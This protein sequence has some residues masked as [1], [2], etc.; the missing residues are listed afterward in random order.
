[1]TETETF[2]AS[3][4]AVAETAPLHDNSVSNANRDTPA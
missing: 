1:M 4:N 3:E 2:N